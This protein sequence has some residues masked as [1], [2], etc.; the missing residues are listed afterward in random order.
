MQRDNS[1][2]DGSFK[3]GSPVS[4]LLS[5]TIYAIERMPI[6]PEVSYSMICTGG[7]DQQDI[8]EMKHIKNAPVP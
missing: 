4:G 3:T 2:R 7:Y 1:F 6:H 8:Q 5:R